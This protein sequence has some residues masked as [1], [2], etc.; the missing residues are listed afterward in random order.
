MNAFGYYVETKI[1]LSTL[2]DNYIAPEEPVNWFMPYVNGYIIYD[3]N[4]L[5]LLYGSYSS[6]SNEI[7]ITDYLANMMLAHNLYN[8]QSISELVNMPIRYDHNDM[9]YEYYISGIIKTDYEDY[10]E[11]D[12]GSGTYIVS[13]YN[14]I[15]FRNLA[16]NNYLYLYFSLQNY[17]K[18]IADT[19]SASVVMATSN[20]DFYI[21]NVVDSNILDSEYIIGDQPVNV[22]EFI[23]T[24]SQILSLEEIN[25]W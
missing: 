6:N 23:I 22:N 8:I 21:Y 15:K 7:L 25:L 4:D 14:I 19:Y 13:D 24:L 1:N 20:N 2:D 10:L 16:E 18:Y 5:D 17:E 9:Q 12:E 3:E 11:F